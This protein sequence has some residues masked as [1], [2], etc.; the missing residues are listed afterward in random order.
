MK[1]TG[2]IFSAAFLALTSFGC[3]QIRELYI[4]SDLMPVDGFSQIDMSALAVLNFDASSIKRKNVD[5]IALRDAVAYDITKALYQINKVRVIQ[6]EAVQS[7]QEKEMVQSSKG[8]FDASST[9]IERV[10]SYKYNPYQKVDVILSGRILDY[11][12]YEPEPAYSYIEIMIKLVDNI[13]GTIYWVTKLRGNYKDVIFTIA[14][15]LSNKNYTEPTAPS[16]SVSA[17]AAVTR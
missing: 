15:T 6:G 4:E 12:Y 13:D 16:V 3:Q 2:L 1:K 7:V 9:Q 14:Q 17:G 5:N 11:K 8:D 10:V